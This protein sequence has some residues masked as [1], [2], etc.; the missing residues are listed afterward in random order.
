[1]AKVVAVCTS[2]TK[3]TV[4]ADVSRCL[5]RKGHGLKGDA[6]AGKWHRQVSMLDARHIETMKSE[7]FAE[8]RYGSFAEN[9]TVEGLDDLSPAVGMR[10][11]VGSRVLLGVSQIGKECHTG[12]EIFKKVGR[13]VMPKKG[14]FAEVLRGGVV[15]VGDVVAVEPDAVKSGNGRRTRTFQVNRRRTK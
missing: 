15:K 11:V 5:V 8:I 9:L 14:V 1:M 12:C 3:G 10:L 4:K 7:G 13:C 6:H 2:G